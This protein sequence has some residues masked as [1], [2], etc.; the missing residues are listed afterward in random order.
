MTIVWPGGNARGKDEER[1]GGPGEVRGS[2]AH[3]E[4]RKLGT[5]IMT[6]KVQVRNRREKLMGLMI[7]M[8]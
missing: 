5:L 3:K 7:L 6:G 4:R 2:K 1:E 8:D